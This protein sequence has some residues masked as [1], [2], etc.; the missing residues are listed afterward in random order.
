MSDYNDQYNEKSSRV[1]QQAVKPAAPAEDR[2][3]YPVTPA[4]SSAMVRHRR[5]DRHHTGEEE[6][7]PVSRRRDMPA[8]EA[9]VQDENEQRE[10]VRQ[11]PA[12]MEDPTDS[13]Y[14]QFPRQAPAYEEDGFMRRQV[15]L[16]DAYEDEEEEYGRPWLKILLIVV[17]VL[18]LLAAAL[19]FVP[20]VGP[21]KPLKDGVVGAVN[22]VLH[23]VS[24]EEKVPAE[25]ISFQTVA[26]NGT[27]N[28]RLLFHLITSK[29]VE[30]VGIQDREG[31]EIPCSVSLVNGEEETN[32]IW[33]ITAV[34]ATPY[35]GE[36]FA[37][38]K[39][40][41][42][43]IR[44]DKWVLLMISD[45][46]PVPTQAPVSTQIPAATLVPPTATPTV[47]PKSTEVIPTQA[48]ATQAPVNIQSTNVPVATWAPTPAPAT[49]APTAA[50]TAVPTPEPTPV[51]TP[52]P[53]PVPTPVPTPEPTAVPTPEP[54][55][56]PLPRLTAEADA[57]TSTT[58]VKVT[59]T[60]FIGGSSQQDFKRE[61][62]Y[63]APNPDNYNRLE[64]GVLTFRGDNFR[65]N[66]S[67]GTVEVEQEEMSVIWKSEIGSLRTKDS[68]TLYGVG[69][70][71]QPAIVKWPVDVRKMMD[72]LYED[73][74]N[75][76][77]LREVI[78]GAQDGK[79]YFL[80]LES[81]EATRDPINVGYPLKGSVAI[82][83]SGRPL[84]SVGQGVSILPSKTGD[85]GLHVFNLINNE[86][87]FFINGRKSNS[88]K[89]YGSNGAFDGTALFLWQDDAMVVA[90]ENGLLYTVDLNSTFTFPTAAEPD[91]EAG[92][93]TQQKTTYLRTK[94]NASKD[95]MT[96]VE[97]S[98][99]MYD[100][101]IY[102][103]DAYGLLRCVDSDTM[104]TVWAMDTGDN[105]DAAIALDMDSAEAVSL[106]TGNTA[107]S[108]L[109]SKKDVSIRKLNALTGE[110][111]WKYDIKC[112]YDKNQQSGCKASPVIGQNGIDDLVIFTVNMV[113]EGGSDVIAFKKES[114]DVAWRYRLDAETISSPVAVYNE[115]G[116]AWIIQADGEGKL[117][118][119]EGDSGKLGSTLDLGGDIQGSPAVYRNILVIG[120]C[121]KD[122]AYMYGIQIK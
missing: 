61:N 72:T 105:T 86:K 55:P 37:A 94:A 60:V 20:N 36:I 16:E 101:Y 17:L 53:T 77:A 58:N 5:S 97:S 33:A 65:R 56:S 35:D 82:D 4:P 6:A 100:K 25:A 121:D 122:N 1:A 40:N 45:P 68:G 8:Q 84:L 104:K 75:T 89:Q 62:G 10:W 70:S 103:A 98:V 114:G 99:A 106:Y 74:R 32:K 42:V 19:Y 85:I 102:M 44:T 24:P 64:I 115:A 111:I 12:P 9:P 113:D 110:E 67:F 3:S 59:D 27:T 79:I 78:F 22:S 43:W 2:A 80:N 50:P 41:D 46:T 11:Q 30:A 7:A 116:D 92:M 87:E 49:P 73:A 71:G 48:P 14:R 90:G 21:L 13:A 52:E 83:T 109:G 29:S 47:E 76:S 112:D 119:L 69:W 118:L 81:G 88:Q 93:E 28:S 34:F 54:T 95:T 96:A 26:N 66:A 15:G 108:R 18:A 117:Y 107:Y 57:S 23:L 39:E 91:K 38:I 51:P 120:T 31:N 63:I